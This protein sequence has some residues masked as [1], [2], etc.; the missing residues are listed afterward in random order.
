MVEIKHVSLLTHESMI[1]G[2]KLGNIFCVI[3]RINN[4]K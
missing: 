4:N 3:I 1:G 2:R